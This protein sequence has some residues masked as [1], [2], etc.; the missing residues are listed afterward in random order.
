M[1]NLTIELQVKT[2]MPM[3][4]IRKYVKQEGIKTSKGIRQTDGSYRSFEVSKID[5]IMQYS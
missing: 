2:D 5:N 4:E 3:T 1:V